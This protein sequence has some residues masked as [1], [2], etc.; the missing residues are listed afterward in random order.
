MWMSNVYVGLESKLTLNEIVR[1]YKKY[2]PR[3]LVKVTGEKSLTLKYFSEFEYK[4][5]LLRVKPVF[6][7]NSVLHSLI[8]PFFLFIYS[9]ILFYVNGF[10]FLLL[11]LPASHSDLPLSSSCHAILRTLI[12][13]VS[14]IVMTVKHHFLI[15][16]V[17]K[18]CD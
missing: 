2:F 4:N 14:E 13:L 12:F 5:P 6:H 3:V 15:R 9:V 16:W 1:K 7:L 18:I 11:P 8:F 10:F 17:N